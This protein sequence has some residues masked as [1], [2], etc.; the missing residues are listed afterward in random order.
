[1]PT[2]VPGP[3]IPV[4]QPVTWTYQVTNGGNSV[5]TNVEVVDDQGV[6]V[7]CPQTALQPG[8]MMECTGSGTAVAGEYANGATVTGTSPTGEVSSEDLSHYFGALGPRR[9]P[10][11]DERRGRGR[12]AGTARSGRGSGHVDVRA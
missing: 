4:G 10:E 2:T 3:L 12:S 1:M 7:T 6:A 11:G 8:E 9:H 5:L